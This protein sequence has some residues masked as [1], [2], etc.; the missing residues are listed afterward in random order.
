[1]N[2]RAWEQPVLLP[3]LQVVPAHP[4]R[5]AKGCSTIEKVRGAPEQLS[6]PQATS[7]PGKPSPSDH[8][9]KQA[10]AILKTETETVTPTQTNHPA[11]A[12]GAPHSSAPTLPTTAKTRILPPK[13][14]LLPGKLPSSC[15]TVQ[16]Q[17]RDKPA[18]RPHA[19]LVPW[20]KAQLPDRAGNL[21]PREKNSWSACTPPHAGTVWP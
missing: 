13:P 14:A 12:A 3:S 15:H 7:A 11:R 5:K 1:M 18:L 8:R 17:L 2:T 4:A 20:P 6:S 21:D 10:S 19:S 16:L 9:S